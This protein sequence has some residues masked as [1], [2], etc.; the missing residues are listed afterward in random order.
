MLMI[1]ARVVSTLQDGLAQPANRSVVALDT[2][3][4]ATLIEGVA[5][6]EP[7]GTTERL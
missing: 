1:G 4:R 5:I 2:E 6:E 7:I 3:P